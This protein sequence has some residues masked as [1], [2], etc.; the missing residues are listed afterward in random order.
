MWL[1]RKYL[2]VHGRPGQL[3]LRS[4][5]WR[6]GETFHQVTWSLTSFVPVTEF[7]LLYRM[8]ASVG[9][10]KGQWKMSIQAGSHSTYT[11]CSRQMFVAFKQ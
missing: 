3:E 7:R 5:S 9:H 8:V 4:E 6:S 11:W 2:E 10:L 1:F